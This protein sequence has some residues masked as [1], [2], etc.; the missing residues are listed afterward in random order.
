M[1]RHTRRHIRHFLWLPVLGLLIGAAV[2]GA[3]SAERQQHLPWPHFG[4]TF[5]TKYASELGLDPHAVYVALLDD[6]GIDRIRLPIYWDEF[7]PHPGQYQTA[8]V[9]W[10]LDEAAKRNVTVIP[11]VGRR[12]PRWPE[13]HPPDWTRQLTEP[14]VR[15]A[16]L[17]MAA[18]VV[19]EFRN[20][21]VVA[22]WQV[23]N[24]PNFPFFGECP[25]P[26]SG[27]LA[28]S[29]DQ[30][31]SLDPMHPIM[32]T[33]SGELST[34]FRLGSQADI[35]GVSLYRAT[36]N[37]FWGHFQYPLPPAYYRAKAWLLSPVIDRIII[38]ELQA[39]PWVPTTIGTTPVEEQRRLMNPARLRANLEYARQTGLP[40][41]YLWGGEWWYWLKETHGDPQMWDAARGI[42]Q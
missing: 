30:V 4:M 14:A 31:R 38:S 15:Q 11:V 36:W 25:W 29:I 8:D 23:Q 35:L 2:L 12:V 1:P 7:E 17:A 10:Y 22:A 19:T 27:F 24:E 21:P 20:H 33:D 26:D 18:T 9:R 3:R 28:T 37:S 6:L 40:E 13:C 39:E 41:A 42:W 16:E 34:W 32:L 5:S